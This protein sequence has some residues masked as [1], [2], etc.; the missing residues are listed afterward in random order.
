LN[1][2]CP[3][4]GR[5]D[6]GVRSKVHPGQWQKIFKKGVEV[7]EKTPNAKGGNFQKGKKRTK[8]SNPEKGHW[9]N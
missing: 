1:V 7:K 3:A 6:R 2:T 5:P 9:E 4:T 8:N